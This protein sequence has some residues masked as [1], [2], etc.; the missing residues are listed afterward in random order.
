MFP[1]FSTV[2]KVWFAILLLKF[3]FKVRIAESDSLKV[4]C[5]DFGALDPQQQSQTLNASSTP[6][7]DVDLLLLNYNV[8]NLRVD[9]SI[10]F[11]IMAA[12]K[13]KITDYLNFSSKFNFHVAITGWAGGVVRADTTLDEQC[14]QVKPQFSTGK[15]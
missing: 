10:T 12:I 15:F 14:D 13:I 3:T 9:L 4:L 2:V 8:G 11:G 7:V 1:E 6:T 5:C